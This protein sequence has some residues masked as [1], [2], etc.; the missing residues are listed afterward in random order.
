MTERIR[1]ISWRKFFGALLVTWGVRFGCLFPL[2]P[3]IEI[4][5]AVF[6]PDLLISFGWFLIDP[7][8]AIE[9]ILARADQ[10]EV[11]KSNQVE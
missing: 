9:Q 7:D 1:K 4:W 10:F 3:S 6:A 8:K 5:V 2:H 11:E